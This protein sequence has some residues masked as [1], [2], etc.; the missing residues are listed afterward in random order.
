[1]FNEVQASALSAKFLTF[2]WLFMDKRQKPNA[3]KMMCKK[4]K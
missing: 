1:M 3:L 4:V 2:Y